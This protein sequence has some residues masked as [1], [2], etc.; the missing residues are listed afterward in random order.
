MRPCR[1]RSSHFVQ[2]IPEANLRCIAEDPQIVEDTERVDNA[3]KSQYRGAEAVSVLPG[4]VLWAA[5][6]AWLN[7]VAGDPAV[8]CGLSVELHSSGAVAIALVT[9]WMLLTKYQ[10][11]QHFPQKAMETEMVVCCG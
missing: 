6:L 5:L 2:G 4:M 3:G 11:D 8:N 10:E 1:L 7:V 9:M